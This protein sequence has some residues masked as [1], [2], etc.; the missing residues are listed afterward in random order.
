LI[1]VDDYPTILL[2][3]TGEKENPLK[4]STKSSAKDMAV[5]INKELKWKDQSGK[6]EL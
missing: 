3:K 2:Y 4:L 1:Q 5:L 6:D